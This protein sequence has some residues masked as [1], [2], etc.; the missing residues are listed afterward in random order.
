MAEA[1]G[2]VRACIELLE[3]A[4]SGDC[5]L[6][7]GAL[8]ERAGLREYLTSYLHLHLAGNAPRVQVRIVLWQC[9]GK[10]AKRVELRE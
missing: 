3:A 9:T 2:L 8:A 6:L 5:E 7:E 1:E 10:L 4:A